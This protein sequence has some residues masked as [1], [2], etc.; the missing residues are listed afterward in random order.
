MTEITILSVTRLSSGVCV[1][2]ITNDGEWIRPTRPRAGGWRYLDYADCEDK[3]ERWIIRKGNTVSM[4]LVRPIPEQDHSED[5][6][7]GTRKPVLIRE[8]PEE[9]YMS[10]CNDIAED[11]IA[12]IEGRVAER[13]LITVHPNEMVSFSFAIETTWEGKRKYVPRCSFRL[14]GH[15]YTGLAIT[16]AEWRGYGRLVMQSPGRH[17]YGAQKIFEDND[18]EDCWLTLGRYQVDSTIYFLVIGIHFFP[19][20]HFDMDFKR[21]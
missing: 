20:R 6:L 3:S 5:W 4:D 11:S 1:A 7:I 19:V 13:S 16:D 12:P 8:L 21:S 17:T 14:H 18:T 9:A 10:L 15:T 2:G